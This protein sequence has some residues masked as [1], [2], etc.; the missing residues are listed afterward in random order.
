M[1]LF[2]TQDCTTNDRLVSPC[3]SQKQNYI[4]NSLSHKDKT[5]MLFFCELRSLTA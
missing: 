2:T 1:Y 4:N 3:V 5:I